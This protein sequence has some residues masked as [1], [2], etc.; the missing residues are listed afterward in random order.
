MSRKRWRRNPQVVARTI[1]GDTI[2]VPTGRGIVDRRCLF[3]LND[4]GGFIWEALAVPST[5]PQI[6]SALAGEFDVTTRQARR[7]LARFLAEL[8]DAGCVIEESEDRKP[9]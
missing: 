6:A 7:D 4:T 5:L 9:G 3:T 8:S 2:L 1:G